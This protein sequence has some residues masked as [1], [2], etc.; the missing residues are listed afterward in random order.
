MTDGTLVDQAVDDIM[1]LL[2]PMQQQPRGVDVESS[3]HV[4]FHAGYE[5]DDGRLELNE[6]QAGLDCDEAVDGLLSGLRE[7]AG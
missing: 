7:R 6:E 4:I 5:D 1:S 3:T 2:T